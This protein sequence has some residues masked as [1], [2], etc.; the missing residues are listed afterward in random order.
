[1]DEFDITEPHNTE[2]THGEPELIQEAPEPFVRSD[3]KGDHVV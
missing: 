2:G 3:R 1:M